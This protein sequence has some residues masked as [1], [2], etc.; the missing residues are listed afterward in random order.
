MYV[1]Q[2]FIF[3]KAKNE[4]KLKKIVFVLF[5]SK[6]VLAFLA[7]YKNIFTNLISN[8]LF[9]KCSLMYKEGF[10]KKNIL[11]FKTPVIVWNW[12]L[13]RARGRSCQFLGIELLKIYLIGR[14]LLLFEN[15]QKVLNHSTLV[16]ILS[17]KLYSLLVRI[18]ILQ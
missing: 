1:F 8:F 13:C 16:R 9:D 12:K 5:R 4:E 7:N 15:C 17:E 6:T 2:A 11:I 14:N 18:Y 3:F 10:L